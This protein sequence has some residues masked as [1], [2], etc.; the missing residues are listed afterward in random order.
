MSLFDDT[1]LFQEIKSRGYLLVIVRPSRFTEKRVSSH[2]ELEEVVRGCSVQLRG[3]D[4]PHIDPARI[5]LRGLDWVGQES[6]W[7][8][9]K[10]IWRIFLSG[11]FA[12]VVGI[13]D[14]W[15]DEDTFTPRR[16]TYTQG[17]S[18]SVYDVVFRMTEIFE[19]SSRLA[20]TPAGDDEMSISVTL[21]GMKGRR[22]EMSEAARGPFRWDRISSVDAIPLQFAVT[23]AEI[24][25]KPRD[26]A[27]SAARQVF[28][29]FGWD[30]AEAIL[31]EIQSKLWR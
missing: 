4:Y 10:E 22:L 2:G 1:S 28:E 17:E 26:L 30:V 29:V 20:L 15:Q 23:K 12:D 25:S 11:Q 18:L 13:T 14:D 31:E 16:T 21:Q 6:D 7:S 3:W 19:F 24:V 5:P 9:F 27:R 8:E